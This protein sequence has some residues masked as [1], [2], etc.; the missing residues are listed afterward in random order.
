MKIL[1]TTAVLTAISYTY[2][3]YADDS[4]SYYGHR[5]SQIYD[6]QYTNQELTSQIHSI[7][8]KNHSELKF[9]LSNRNV[10]IYG[11]IANPHERARIKREI[12]NINGVDNVYFEKGHETKEKDPPVGDHQLSEEI[13]A[14][15]DYFKKMY[16]DVEVYVKDGWVTLRGKVSTL[17]EKMDLDQL[18]SKFEGIFGVKNEVTV[19]PHNIGN[20]QLSEKVQALLNESKNLYQDVKVDVKKGWV[21]LRGNVS[22]L[23][24]KMHLDKLIGKIEG[25][26]GIKNKVTVKNQ[27]V[28]D[29]QLSQEILSLLNKSKNLYQDVE[30]D[31]KKGWV[32]LRG[33]VLTL[34]EKM[35]LDK[36]ISKVKGIVGIK[37]EVSVRHPSSGDQQ[38]ADEI[39]N[40]LD[41]FKKAYQDVEVYVKNGWVTLQGEVSTL[42]EKL[43]LEELIDKIKGVLGVENKITVK[44]QQ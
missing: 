19:K 14:R 26:V 6:K 1:I 31:V 5:P 12:Q 13:E 11:E 4:S 29:Y 40:R 42:E 8:E 10:I 38:L 17:E 15:L 36:L 24:E 44:K 33:E 35:N 2:S 37:N 34:E 30:V 21:T 18:I 43:H 39:Q 7:L 9:A 22:T 32:T 25:V 16:Q 3:G 41:Y 23:E 27:N 20:Q 28:G